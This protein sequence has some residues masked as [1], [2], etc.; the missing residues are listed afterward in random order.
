MA[1]VIPCDTVSEHD[2]PLMNINI[3]TIKFQPRQK[4]IRDFKSFNLSDFESDFAQLTFSTIYA[5]EDP[6]EQLSVFNSLILECL[7]VHAPIKTCKMTRP[8]A[9]WMR[10]LKITTLQKEDKQHRVKAHRSENDED[11]KE[12][13]STKNKLKME[14]KPTKCRFYK[15]AFSSRRPKEV[16]QFMGF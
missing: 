1:D 11:W 6:N 2:C 3:K 13:R 14:T 10:D 7:N 8:P 4:S 12:Y 15:K 9:P 5:F 16:W